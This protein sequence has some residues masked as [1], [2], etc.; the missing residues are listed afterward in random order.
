M[1]PWSCEVEMPELLSMC[2]PVSFGLPMVL[3]FVYKPF[4]FK[5]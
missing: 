4:L 3:D 5:Y 2:R 1:A